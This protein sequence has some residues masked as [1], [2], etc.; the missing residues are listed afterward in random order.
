M[1]KFAHPWYFLLILVI[2]T[3]LWWYLKI[4]K[5]QEGTLRISS[6]PLLQE[7]F[8]K[9]G[10]FRNRFLWIIQLGSLLCI[11]LALARPRLVDSL[12][13][14]SVEIVDIVM[15]VDISSSMLAEDFKPNR[16]EAVKETAAKF[17][18]KRSGDRIGLL[19][20][21]GETFIQC[22]LTVDTEMLKKLLAEVTIAE[23]DYDGTAIG[24][25]IAN[26][27]N[28]LRNSE[29]KSKVMVLLSDG[30]N[31]AGELDPLTAADLAAEFDIKIYTIGAGTNQSVTYIPNRG[32]I[33]NEIDE[34][35]LQAIAD[36]THG[37][38]YRATDVESLEN[39]YEEINQLE[40]TEIEIREYT[41]Y[42]ELYSWFLF[43]ALFFRFGFEIF[44]RIIFKRKT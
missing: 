27:T 31:N 18:E 5:N 21:A 20:F 12:E 25:A 41:R 44:E 26:A 4:G 2:P 42:K 29:A 16:L 7:R 32:Y 22:P 19:V 14:T 17:I 34:K 33:R 15:V 36:E 38:Y 13:E 39:I 40:R 35:T 3:L 11:I 37:R 28:R 43:P 1:I 23:K 10:K 24:M 30:S 9:Q 6:I 8:I